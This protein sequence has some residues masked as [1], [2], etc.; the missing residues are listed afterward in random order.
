MRILVTGGTGYLGQAVVRAL[1]AAGHNMSIFARAAS[2]WTLPG[3][4][5]DGDIRDRGALLRAGTNCDVI[6][7]LAALVSLWH[8][9]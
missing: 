5:I 8:P 6:C 4:A 9:L 3:K 1:A 2:R 7:H